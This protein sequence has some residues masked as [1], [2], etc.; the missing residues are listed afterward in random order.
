MAT[1]GIQI[2]GANSSFVL[3][4]E[5]ATATYMPVVQGSTSVSNGSSYSNYTLGD[6]IYAKPSA[7]S[8][9]IYSD[10]RDPSDPKAIGNQL[11]VLLRPSPT[12]PSTTQNGSIYGLKVLQQGRVTS[13][14]VSGGSGYLAA[15]AVTIAGGDGVTATGTAAISSGSV[16]GI[17]ITNEGN[18][19]KDIP[20]ITIGAPAAQQFD[21]SSS[22]IVNLTNNTITLT[23]SQAGTWDVNDPLSYTT[24][25]TAIGGLG[26]G[27]T[28][29]VK[30]KSGNAISLSGTSG[31]SEI[32][33]TGYG[34]GTVHRFTGQTATATAVLGYSTMYDS[35]H[36]AA[37]INVK[38]SKGHGS[39]PG[40]I[41]GGYYGSP[42]ESTANQIYTS[43]TSD[44]YALMNGMQSYTQ[45]FMQIFLGYN[46]KASS[47]I[48]YWA[49]YFRY[50]GWGQSGQGALP[51]FATLMVGDL[52][53]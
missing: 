4:S 49:G 13:A 9:V 3:D 28:Y 18:G 37:G 19:Y 8:G 16:T 12:A 41:T 39:C 31:G 50:S 40:G 7:G 15:P 51:N 42:T 52:I 43:Y 14:T 38:A 25:G 21:G 23:S 17:T 5:I 10:F 34:A 35:R 1:Y 33:L 26:N 44:T 53:T 47:T 29:Y 11:F 22:S 46:F 30:T 32:N 45:G 24:T 20:A 27:S 6:L 36:T 48:V 2:N